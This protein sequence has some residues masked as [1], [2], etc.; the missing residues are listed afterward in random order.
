M[1]S[2]D[3]P[4][5]RVHLLKTTG[6]N[7]SGG[8]GT[9][10]YRGA[11]GALD[12]IGLTPFLGDAGSVRTNKSLDEPCGGFSVTFADRV[13]NEGA[14]TVAALAEAM[15]MVEIRM[16]RI[17][18]GRGGVPPLIMRGYISSV[19][20]VE[21][22]DG[23]GIPH[24]VVVIMGQDSGKLWQNHSILPEAQMASALN[25]MLST[26]SL[27][28]ATGIT[29]G[30]LPVAEFVSIFTEQVMNPAVDMMSA[31]AGRAVPRFTPVVSVPADQGHISASILQGFPGGRFWDV[32]EYVADRPWNELF[33]RDRPDG[34][35][36]ELVF[37]P[38]PYLDIGGGI[39]M[40]GAEEPAP[41]IVRD[42]RDIVRLDVVRSDHDVANFYWVPPT[43]SI[44]DTANMSSIK[45]IN[46]LAGGQDGPLF[47]INHNNSALA[48]YG[49]RKMEAY[50][51][52]MP[53]DLPQGR[54]ANL[55][56]PDVREQAG[57]ITTQWH[58]RRAE[59]LKLLNL[60][61]VV[62]ETVEMVIKGHEEFEIGRYIE[63]TRGQF[64]GSGLVSKGYIQ[65]VQHEFVPL[66]HGDSG[67]WLTT[68]TIIR[69]D[70]FL[71]RDEM[72]ASPYWTEGR[73]GP[74]S[75]GG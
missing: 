59:Q 52:L 30:I 16:K 5:V 38:V 14:D 70:G 61:N 41:L 23:D 32:L 55:H 29:F 68:L 56:D 9:G 58:I 3:W 45:E 24:R 4:D 75:P 27:F 6:V 1:I 11:A 44:P 72:G 13:S 67:A 36:P 73:R 66:K 50:T 54:S 17:P 31:F 28:A 71:N 26:Y 62:W 57:E 18:A 37:R 33:V 63:W 60:D 35:P 22:I 64:Y 10:Q 46:R 25:T 7:F 8:V 65:R 47:S 53:S 42:Q 43:S 12:E 39:I 49:L 69:S 51:R 21:Y 40:P 15:D 20:R 48:L 2:V 74:Y 19:R 34:G